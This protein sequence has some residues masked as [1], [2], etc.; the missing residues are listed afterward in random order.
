[1][2]RI[3]KSLLALD[4]FINNVTR[5]E[6]EKIWLEVKAMNIS[7]PTVVEYFE[8]LFDNSNI[9]FKFDKGIEFCGD[10][11]PPENVFNVTIETPKYSLESFFIISEYGKNQPS[12]LSTY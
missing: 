10:N 9:K 2:N 3:T 12:G 7:G 1:M 8:N 6:K 4:D 11:K 5:S